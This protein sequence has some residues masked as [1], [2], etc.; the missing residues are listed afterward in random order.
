MPMT[1]NDLKNLA[2][3]EINHE[4]ITGWNDQSNTDIPVVN[5]Q[6]TLAVAVALAK[7]PWSFATKYAVLHMAQEVD[8]GT[9]PF[10]KYKYVAELPED[11]V[12]YLAAYTEKNCNMLGAYETIGNKIYTNQQTLYLKYIGT[13]AESAY[14]AEYVDWFKVFFAARLNP[15]LNGDM[16]RQQLLEAQEPVLFRAAKNIDTKRNKHQSLITN[17]LLAIRGRFGGG[18][19]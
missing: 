5:Q 1:A 4:T 7:Y 8:P 15:Y 19:I 12:G 2:L 16:Q 6:Y 14:P 18:I 17:P 3:M 13:V 11:I 9:E 10:Q